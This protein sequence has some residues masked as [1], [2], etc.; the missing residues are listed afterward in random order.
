MGEICH[1]ALQHPEM[2][3]EVFYPIA[4]PGA[5]RFFDVAY[6]KKQLG[7]QPRYTFDDLPIRYQDDIK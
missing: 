5:D 1:L 2:Q 6:L 4:G 7:W 3:Y